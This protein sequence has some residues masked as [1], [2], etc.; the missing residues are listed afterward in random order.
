MRRALVA[1]VLLGASAAGCGWCGKGA[2][3]VGGDAAPSPRASPPPP[4]AGAA[5]L[6]DHAMWVVARD[7]GAEED[8]ATLAVHEG[9]AGLVE[10][11]QDPAL[12]PTAIRAMAFARGWAQM[13]YLASVASGEAEEEARL[14]LEIAADL[15]A[16]SRRAE[17]PEDAEE[18]AEACDKLRALAADET[19]PRPRPRRAG[20]LR[21][22]RMMP[23]PRPEAGAEPGLDAK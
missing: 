20:A 2:Q 8:L 12:R 13:P 15:A 19:R 17:D 22:L 21:A 5:A 4:D 7:G 6:R 3:P 23:C 14:A 10:A 16:R 1:V 18:L 11:A 9:A